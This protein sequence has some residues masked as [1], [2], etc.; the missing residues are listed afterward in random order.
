[1]LTRGGFCQ[2]ENA[3]TSV[4]QAKAVLQKATEQNN[5]VQHEEAAATQASFEA[6]KQVTK[7]T[8]AVL[9]APDDKTEEEA[10]TGKQTALAKEVA[11]DAEKT[12]MLPEEKA[13][14]ASVA[15]ADAKL[16][17]Q[18]SRQK[19]AEAEGHK[20]DLARKQAEAED[21]A[22]N[23]MLCLEKDKLDD[24][25]TKEKNSKLHAMSQMVQASKVEAQNAEAAQKSASSAAERE[26]ATVKAEAAQKRVKEA[27]AKQSAADTAEELE[28]KLAE[29]K[30]GK[31]TAE[32]ME[33]QA[34]A[35]AKE[36]HTKVQ[37]TKDEV[38]IAKRE[39]EN[40]EAAQKAAKSAA[41]KQAAAM[42]QETAQMKVKEASAKERAAADAEE[43]QS[44]LAVMRAGNENA[45]QSEAESKLHAQG[46]KKEAK[47]KLE[48]SNKLVE[49]ARQEAKNAEASQKHAK[50]AAEKQA[51]TM[52]AEVAEKKVS[53]A[54]EKERAA[55]ESKELQAKLVDTKLGLNVSMATSNEKD[56]KFRILN[57]KMQQ[58][59]LQPQQSQST[60]RVMKFGITGCNL[61]Y[62]AVNITQPGFAKQSILNE[63]NVI[64]MGSEMEL[65][66]CLLRGV[67]RFTATKE[68]NGDVVAIAHM[69]PNFRDPETKMPFC[70]PMSTMLFTAGV[71]KDTDSEIE[72]VVVLQLE[73][74]GRLVIKDE[75]RDIIVRLDNIMY[76]P[77]VVFNKAPDV[78]VPY[79]FPTGMY[80]SSAPMGMSGVS[81]CFCL[82]F[83][84]WCS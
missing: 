81:D 47:S 65:R 12:R 43:L 57:D 66:T 55:E 45:K 79:C 11:A 84:L 70:F 27:S 13:S 21:K 26:A 69:N 9:T 34:K 36:K 50:S 59:Q 17:E 77:L 83:R 78:C 7:Q 61:E 6:H 73:P 32:Q 44:K 71:V 18:V 35:T 60:A 24:A 41:D 49:V 58:Q 3:K 53:E 48:A 82:F 80:P 76:H 19:Q 75:S 68:E 31:M 20:A 56:T 33:L 8:Q 16:K 4:A 62:N 38:L 14:T 54:A 30:A 2:A 1:M 40:A 25:H 46:E 37:A 23:N 74:H 72:R 5:K 29:M 51:A 42:G 28:I 67:A 15:Y 64:I 22:L 63:S 52:Q 10:K 39:A